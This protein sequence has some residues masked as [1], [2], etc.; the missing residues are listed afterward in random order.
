MKLTFS[1][2]EPKLFLV[3]TYGIWWTRPT[4]SVSAS[5]MSS[6]VS[7]ATASVNKMPI[8]ATEWEV[9][10]TTYASS[11]LRSACTSAQSD[12]SLTLVLLNR[13]MPCFCKQCKSVGF[14]RSQLIWIC[15]VCHSVWI[16]IIQY[17]F[18]SRIWIKESD[19]LTIRNGCGILIY[20]AGQGLTFAGRTPG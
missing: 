18:I 6:K 10:L 19:W 20:S 14:W 11:K 4:F 9:H 3:Q 1:A 16:Y 13:D 17:E 7:S 15:T 5:F 12:Q 2:W 8:W